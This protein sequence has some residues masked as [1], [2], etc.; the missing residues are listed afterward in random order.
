ML[1]IIDKLG[2]N[3]KIIKILKENGWEGS[4][5]RFAMQKNRGNLTTDVALILW[6]YC[7]KHKI[8]VSRTDFYAG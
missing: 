1:K 3:S 4:Y 7:L 6:E 5:S 8:P 2:S